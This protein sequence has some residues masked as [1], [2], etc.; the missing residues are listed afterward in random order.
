[1]N[2]GIPFLR[3]MQIIDP[4]KASAATKPVITAIDVEE[5]SMGLFGVEIGSIFGR[6]VGESV[7]ED[8]GVGVWLGVGGEVG[9]A[10]GRAAVGVGCVL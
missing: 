7:G 1:M 6:C 10:V 5:F 4:A 3:L 8:M 9:V 2:Y